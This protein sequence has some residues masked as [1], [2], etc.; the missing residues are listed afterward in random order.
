MFA[1]DDRGIRGISNIVNRWL[2]L[3]VVV[4]LLAALVFTT[5]ASDIAA[6]FAIPAASVLI[7]FSFAWA[8][9]SASL[10]QDKTFSRFLIEYAPPVQHYIYAFQL[11]IL[12]CI[13][14]IVVDLII[15][16]G[17][18]GLTSGDAGLNDQINK[19]ILF[20]IGS[21]ALR[22]CW[23]VINFV[24]LLTLQYYEVRRV[25]ILGE[26]VDQSAQ[27]SSN[28]MVAGADPMPPNAV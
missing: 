27:L 25:E 16:A 23:G 19:A 21:L 6:K 11:A 17:G 15:V 22:E 14:Y 8:G 5:P 26:G 7:G 28:E 4:G 12:V 9:R 2:V 13:I 18:I 3:H 24:N 20:S 1:S 10:F